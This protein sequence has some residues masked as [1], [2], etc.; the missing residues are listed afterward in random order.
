M[1]D[2]D[3][4]IED[5][6][7]RTLDPPVPE[8]IQ[9]AIL[10]LQDIGALSNDEKLTRLGEKLGAL[11][12]HPSTS[13]MLFFAILMNC[14]DPALTLACASDYRDP[15]TLPMLPNE[16]KRAAAAKAELASLYNGQGDH[17]AIIAA[18]ECW[19]KAKDRGQEG[20]FCS[21]YFVSSST[22]NMLLGM[23]KQLE[24]E[25]FHNGFIPENTSNCSI[26]ATDPGIVHAVLVAGLY[27]MV[28]KL[29]PPGRGKRLVETANGERVR[30]HSPSAK[31]AFS[32]VSD[33]LLVVYDEITRGEGM[34]YI[35]NCT[36]V[37]PLPVLLLAT[38]IAVAP[39]KENDDEGF[40]YESNEEDDEYDSDD[41]DEVEM[42]K[43]VPA[44]RTEKMM[45]SPDSSVTVVADGW[46]F[47][48]STSLDFAQV[49]CLQEQL[50]EAMLFKVFIFMYATWLKCFCDTYTNIFLC[51]SQIHLKFFLQ[52]L[53]LMYI[54]QHRFYLMMA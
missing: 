51:R 35:R 30:L 37:G 11:P 44:G 29:L 17:L 50:L 39:G 2:P 20:R 33:Q 34:G 38:E 8:T 1:L 27:P 14:L 36:I 31:P 10:L 7:L 13:K 12:I 3:C 26:N 45:S 42:N 41:E 9:N 4:K 46:L 23:R 16:K 22:M 47:F 48:E 43:N 28:G 49:Y 54:R 6:L 21:Q 40:G 5:F 19:K 18:F 52:S 15:F 32:K 53:R 25:L 24:R